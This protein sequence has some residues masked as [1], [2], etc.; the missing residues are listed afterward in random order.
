METLDEKS[1]SNILPKRPKDANKGIFGKVLIIA[2]SENFPG[3]AYLACAGAYRV[4][5]GLV[6]LATIPVVQN[7]VS[8]KLPEAT[9]IILPEDAGAIGEMALDAIFDKI[10]H[11]VILIG[12]GLGRYEGTAKFIYQ[13]LRIGDLNFVIDGDGLNILSTI[14]DWDRLLLNY[15]SSA[16]LTP[17]PGE[18]ARLTKLSVEDIQKGRETVAQKYADEWGQIVV[19]KGAN[20]VIASPNGERKISP[21]ANPLLATAGTGDILSGMITGFVAQG[22][23]DFDGACC[24]VYIHGMIGEILKRRMGDAG[25]LAS[26]LIPLIPKVLNQLKKI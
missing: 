5:A 2:G 22:L 6:T 21:F 10:S 25:M 13:L 1:I 23:N 24:G 8:K 4:G 11:D 19:L 26:D 12:P 17:H 20:S 18:M 16:V 3:A 15:G 7:I 14:N 9:Y